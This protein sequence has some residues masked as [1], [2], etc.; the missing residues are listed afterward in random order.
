[1]KVYTTSNDEL[2]NRLIQ[3]V[4]TYQPSIVEDSNTIDIRIQ[5]QSLYK[6]NKLNTNIQK[7]I[8]KR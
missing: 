8:N 7:S 4:Q 5:N 6:F 1:M 2:Y 3:L